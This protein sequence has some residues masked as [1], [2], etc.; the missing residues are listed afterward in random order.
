MIYAYDT[1][2]IEHTVRV[3][4][5][6]RKVH[7][8]DLISI[9]IVCEDGREYYAVV[10]NAPWKDI[11]REPW[12]MDN[13]IPSLPQA[14][15]DQRNH[16]PKSWLINFEDPQVKPKKKIATEVRDFLLAGN[17]LPRLWANYGAYDHV[18]LAGGLFGR[19]IDLPKGLPM[20][21]ND[22]QQEA[23]RRSVAI[24]E[25]GEGVHN[26]LEDARHVMRVLREWGR[27]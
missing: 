13:V 23:A 4:R 2:F 12:L 14:Y 15:G 24:V 19:M 22:I 25:Q 7:T 17:G 27:V 8:I 18:V 10:E 21:T 5:L 20:W 6:G 26:A 3:G 1:E 16:L 9:G 11:Q